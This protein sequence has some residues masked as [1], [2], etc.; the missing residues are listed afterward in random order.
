LAN[1]AN[2]VEGAERAD[3]EA[4][5]NFIPLVYNAPRHKT[6]TEDSLLECVTA[7]AWGAAEYGRRGKYKMKQRKPTGQRPTIRKG[8]K[9]KRAS[10]KQKK[11]L[12][13]AVYDSQQ[14]ALVKGLEQVEWNAPL[15]RYMDLSKFVFM[16]AT[17]TLPLM[18][19]DL[20]GDKHEG[21]VPPPLPNIEYRGFL[22]DEDLHN[23]RRNYEEA[24]SARKYFFASCWH[25]ND[26]ESDAMWKLYL[27]AEGLA[28]RTTYS[29][30]IDSL[31]NATEDF[32]VGKIRYGNL[33]QV[34]L[35][36]QAC[37][38]KRTPFK[39]EQEVRVIWHDKES[40]RSNSGAD[41]RPESKLLTCDLGT[42]VERIYVGPHTKQWFMEA[43]KDLL[44]KYGLGDVRV[45]PSGLCQEPN[46]ATK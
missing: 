9:Q 46:W 27:K 20:L 5:G 44:D 38:R 35:P 23:D 14:K 13:N 29:S 24:E 10:D 3:A 8:C 21:F 2:C 45:L 32:L 43:I 6:V 37:M 30:L 15:W 1:H 42:L 16:L 41:K 31:R 7:S 25:G 19:L 40:A 22:A 11:I 26:E 12:A 28:I 17:K 36:L 33:R 18:R 39:H 34:H 4:C